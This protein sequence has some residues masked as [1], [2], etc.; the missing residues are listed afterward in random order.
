MIC[1]WR[2]DQSRYFVIT[3]LDFNEYLYE[4]KRSAIFV[5]EQLQKGEKCCFIYA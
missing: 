1:Q 2:G 5:Q 4:V 3:K